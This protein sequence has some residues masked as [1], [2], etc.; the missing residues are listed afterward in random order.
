MWT[1][2]DSASDLP[3]RGWSRLHNKERLLGQ[4]LLTGQLPPTGVFF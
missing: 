2:A 1:A 4:N 3:V